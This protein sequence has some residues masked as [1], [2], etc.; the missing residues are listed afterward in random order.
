MKGEESHVRT[1]VIAIDGGAGTGKTTSAAGVAVRLG[2]CYVDSGAIYRAVAWALR[3][4]GVT[5]PNASEVVEVLDRMALR[6]EPDPSGFRVYLDDRLVADEIRTPEISTLS[7]KFAI[8]AAVR[9][10]VTALL[11][12]AR[13]LGPMVVEGR[14]I[15]TAVFPDADLKVF[16]TAQLPIRAER[17]QLDLAR[18]GIE[19]ESAQVAR[20]LVERD[21]R[22]AGREHAPLSRALDAI[23]VDT[24]ATSIDEQVDQIVR[25]YHARRV[26]PRG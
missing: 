23:D 5:D 22:D 12:A 21:A 13:Q 25:A 20:D 14:D 6:I 26:P 19:L 18:Q 4:A 2:Y 7:S 16:L 9:E 15:G 8:A 17:R 24:S 10:K 1:S 3:S 11:R